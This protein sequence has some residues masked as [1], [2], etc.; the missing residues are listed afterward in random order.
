MWTKEVHLQKVVCTRAKMIVLTS[1][2]PTT[3]ATRINGE[4]YG[5]CPFSHK[6]MRHAEWVS[7]RFRSVSLHHFSSLATFWRSVVP[8]SPHAL[9]AT[10]HSPA[11]TS[12]APP[13]TQPQT[14]SATYPTLHL[15]PSTPCGPMG[16]F[17]SV[18]G[19]GGGALAAQPPDQPAT[20]PP[21]QPAT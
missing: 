19:R 10:P 7:F 18:G 1:C 11:P 9:H 13:Q 2:T 17:P 5:P 3:P 12:P 4:M 8:T 6:P 20:R 14:L 15:Q 21:S 16:V